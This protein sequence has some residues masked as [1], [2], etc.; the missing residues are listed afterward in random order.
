LGVFLLFPSLLD[1]N[2]KGGDY[3]GPLVYKGL[4]GKAG[5]AASKPHA[6]DQTVSKKLWKFSV[7]LTG[8]TDEIGL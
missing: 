5:K 2:V 6:D 3:F 4:T 7:K 8:K 1:E